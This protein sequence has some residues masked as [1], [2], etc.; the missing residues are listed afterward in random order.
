MGSSVTNTN[1]RF[2]L[3]GG[4]VGGNKYVGDIY[5]FVHAPFANIPVSRRMEQSVSY[6]FK[7]ST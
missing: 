6:S 1:H 7:L 3:G 2:D 5:A 4:A